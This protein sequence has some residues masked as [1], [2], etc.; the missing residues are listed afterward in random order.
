MV[1]ARA[2]SAIAP[3]TAKMSTDLPS[4]SA[5]AGQDVRLDQVPYVRVTAGHTDHAP[6][7]GAGHALRGVLAPEQAGGLDQRRLGNRVRLGRPPE[8]RGDPDPH[9]G[10]G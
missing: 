6:L 10:D 1:T 3:R 7:R 5:E 4:W 9:S 2:A 8:P